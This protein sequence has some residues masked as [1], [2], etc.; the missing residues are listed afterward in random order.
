M[1]ELNV[2]GEPEDGEVRMSRCCTF[3]FEVIGP[4]WE[5]PFLFTPVLQTPLRVEMLASNWS[6]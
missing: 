4:E 2:H 1:S 3:D 6:F 5:T